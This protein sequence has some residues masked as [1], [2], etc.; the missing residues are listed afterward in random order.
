MLQEMLRMLIETEHAGFS[1]A[2]NHTGM[3]MCCPNL[4]LQMPTQS[5]LL[6][7]AKRCQF[8]MWDIIIG[9]CGEPQF[10]TF[11]L[12]FFFF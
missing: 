2:G 9:S 12:S 1:A 8:H 4:P 5:L 7:S 10:V 3:G 11:P 6:L